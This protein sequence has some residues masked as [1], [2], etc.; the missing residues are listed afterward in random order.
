MIEGTNP[1]SLPGSSKPQDEAKTSESVASIALSVLASTQS[2]PSPLDPSKV[3][4]EDTFIS[5][6]KLEEEGKFFV[7]S[8]QLDDK[9]IN[10]LNIK[11]F[12]ATQKN[13][14]SLAR[15]ISERD[16]EVVSF[17]K[18]LGICID[19]VK[20]TLHFPQK[21]FL[22]EK[23]AEYRKDNPT[24]PEL[25]LIE[26]TH[27]LPPDDFLHLMLTKD[28]ILSEPPDLI[29]DICFHVIPILS[30]VFKFR[31]GYKPYKEMIASTFSE[32]QEG[33]RKS[34]ENF[35]KFISPVNQILAKKQ[36]KI[37]TKEEWHLMQDILRF[38]MSACLDIISTYDDAFEQDKE[39]KKLLF[40]TQAYVIIYEDRP[41]GWDLVYNKK[42]PKTGDEFL[43]RYRIA[44]SDRSKH[45]LFALYAQPF[46]KE[47]E[48]LK[49]GL[50]SQ[51]A[52]AKQDP[53]PFLTSLDPELKKTIPEDFWNQIQASL[54]GAFEDLS[55]KFFESIESIPIFDNEEVPE[56][57]L[58]Y[59][60]I[61]HQE[62]LEKA[63]LHLYQ[64]L[65]RS[66]HIDFDLFKEVITSILKKPS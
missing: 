44:S 18:S 6:W 24:F 34:S 27:I 41:A 33:F 14:D 59:L 35:D 21:S 62:I 42:F 43:R 46:F 20:R 5:G 19:T 53:T 57:H 61:S 37:I 39:L 60:F 32:L 40:Q 65:P 58:P 1:S 9:K 23:I 16:P 17:L 48:S 8:Q 3:Q 38:S 64:S 51:L 26:V 45:F 28:I 66:Q 25:S 52:Q 49:D 31:Q 4:T 7:C 2:A 10:E 12:P 15:M 13:F 56:E 63:L 30:R 54:E 47:V 11:Q 55:L 22:K 36:E 29:H 50:I